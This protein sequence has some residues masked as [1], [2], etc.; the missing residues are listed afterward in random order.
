MTESRRKHRPKEKGSIPG[1]FV[2]RLVEMLESPANQVLSLSAKRVMERLE[3]EL[4]HHVNKPAENGR[5]PCTYEHFV[6]FGIERHAIAPAIREAVALGFVEITRQGSAG[7]A[8]FRQPTHYRLT[9]RHAGLDKHITDEWRRI[10]TKDEAKAIA[11]R[12]RVGAPN[13]TRSKNKRPMRE[14]PLTP[15]RETPTENAN[16]PVRETPTTTPV[17]ETPTTSISRAG[18]RSSLPAV[19]HGPKLAWSRPVVIEPTDDGQRRCAA[20]VESP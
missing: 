13:G 15:V 6:E 16:S 4:G 14:N 8:D 19:R 18:A 3:I 20:F 2:W 5:L 10:T 9:Y 11:R 1:Q 12:A 17:Q 7:N